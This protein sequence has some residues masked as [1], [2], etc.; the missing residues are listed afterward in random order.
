[1]SS[2]EAKTEGK[3]GSLSA[4]SASAEST[5]KKRLESYRK[6]YSKERNSVI[7]RQLEKI[8]G[9]DVSDSAII[10][11]AALIEDYKK[12]LNRN[13]TRLGQLIGLYY[14]TKYR[15]IHDY[16]GL[17]KAYVDGSIKD[18]AI[19]KKPASEMGLFLNKRAKSVIAFQEEVDE[20]ESMME[21]LLNESY[22]NFTLI[23]T[24]K[25]A[26]R[27]IRKAG[28][29]SALSRMSA[30]K[31]QL[32]VAEKALFRHLKNRKQNPP[33]YGILHE[34]PLMAKARKKNHGK[35][36]RL[37]ADKLIIAA[38]MDYFKS[39]NK[40]YASKMQKEIEK[41]AREYSQ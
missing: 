18:D 39:E 28:S 13:S 19:S 20:A 21:S 29:F 33:K 12:S 4:D 17:A 5:L 3:G 23:A 35:L 6:N 15:G 40:K 8:R 22:P 34:H 27:L 37:I 11:L 9:Q 1:M 26:Y 7:E 32:M 16:A 24:P 30:S 25:I 14:P 2:S 38:R 41:K 36:A 10:R 31:L